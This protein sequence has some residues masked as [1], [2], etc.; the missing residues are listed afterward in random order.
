MEALPAPRV[1][2]LACGA[3]AREL[4]ELTST[5]R[6]DNV[7][8][9]CLPAALHN[10]PAKIPAALRARL[11]TIRDDYD[12]VLVGYADCGTAGAIDEL[13]DELGVER[14][15][16]AHCYEVYAGGGRF[17][18]MH[19]ADPTVFYVTDFL[20]RHFDRLV[21]QGLGIAEHPELLQQYFGN[22][23]TLRYLAQTADQQ[24][25]RDARLAATKLGLRFERVQTGYGDLSEVVV[26]L[27]GALPAQLSG[28]GAP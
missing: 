22:Y 15:P 6:L 4:L 18:E 5:H 19:E 21:M 1:L 2:V 24:L 3:L 8:I 28:L 20:V 27:A 23:T 26:A 25:D 12:T 17:H 9:E 10:Q 7:R 16:G 11:E 13:C 14:L